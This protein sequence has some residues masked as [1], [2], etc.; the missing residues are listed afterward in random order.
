MPTSDDEIFNRWMNKAAEFGGVL[1]AS[2]ASR[3]M[4]GARFVNKFLPTETY[5]ETLALKIKPEE[6]LKL[7]FSVLSKLGKLETNDDIKPPYPMLKAV[8]GV[9]F[10]DMNPAIVRLKIL[11][12]DSGECE[13]RIT[14]AAKDGLIKRDT[15]STAVK[16]VVSELRETTART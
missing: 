16:R 10:L 7:G 8:V 2:I 5:A 1:P 11:A 9:G 3:L 15:A 4:V 12:G 13:L 6:A 14:A